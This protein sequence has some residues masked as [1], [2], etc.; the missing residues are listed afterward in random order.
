MS[1]TTQNPRTMD[2]AQLVAYLAARRAQAQA[3]Y[4]RQQIRDADFIAFVAATQPAKT[5]R[6]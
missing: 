4:A 1:D 3:Q 5:S 6:P 2:R